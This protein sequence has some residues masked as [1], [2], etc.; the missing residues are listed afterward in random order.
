M[1]FK[2]L[3]PVDAKGNAGL[4][5][6]SVSKPE[7]THVDVFQPRHRATDFRGHRPA[8]EALFKLM[9]AGGVRHGERGEVAGIPRAGLE[10]ELAGGIPTSRLLKTGIHPRSIGTFAIGSFVI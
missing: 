9:A 10:A 3:S 6:D 1:N 2:Y 5:N 7:V 4:K 8:R